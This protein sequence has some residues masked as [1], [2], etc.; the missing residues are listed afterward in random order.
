MN[1]IPNLKVAA[2][3]A[4]T[5]ARSKVTSFSYSLQCSVLPS[6][7]P[8]VPNLVYRFRL[9]DTVPK[10]VLH[11][12]YDIYSDYLYEYMETPGDERMI[13]IVKK[14]WISLPPELV[15]DM[16][17]VQNKIDAN[18]TY[19]DPVPTRIRVR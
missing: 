10:Y 5:S 11:Q 14:G 6:P 1:R 4:I 18:C 16:Y 13:R 15:P 3:F 2:E 8:I 12:I 19:S 9:K 17:Y 7:T